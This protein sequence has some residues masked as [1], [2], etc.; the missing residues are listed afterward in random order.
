MLRMDISII[1]PTYE[2]GNIFNKTLE[3]VFQSTSHLNC[4]IIVVNDSKKSKPIIGKEYHNVQLFNNPRKGCTSA[5]NFGALQA[6]SEF[7][8][9]LDDDFIITQNSIN[10]IL[11]YLKNHPNKAFNVAWEYPATLYDKI[12]TQKVGRYLTYHLKFTSY[13]DRIGKNWRDKE[14]FLNPQGLGSGF[15]AISKAAFLKADGYNEE[16]VFAADR[17]MAKRLFSVGVSVFIV[18]NIQVF[19]NEEDKLTLKKFFERR[20]F[21]VYKAVNFGIIP[22]V[23]YGKIKSIILTFLIFIRPLLYFVAYIIPN[24]RILDKL[25][26]KV[27]D[28]LFVSYLYQ[29]YSHNQF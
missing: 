11:F 13:K 1:I 9:F 21:G 20:R 25:Y 22:R 7:L 29:A 8:L 6:S 4:E 5:R 27:A 3:S 26:Y 19:H 14:L 15:F 2:R 17:D 16:Y 18:P 12:L 24:I 28:L 23:E 10:K